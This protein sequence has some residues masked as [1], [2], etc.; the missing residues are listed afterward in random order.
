[1]TSTNS[2]AAR[3]IDSSDIWRAV[4]R[5]RLYYRSD[6][7]LEALMARHHLGQVAVDRVTAEAARHV[8]N[9]RRALAAGAAL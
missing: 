5:H 3:G 8:R 4:R 1:M 6:L 7:E 2:C 9:L